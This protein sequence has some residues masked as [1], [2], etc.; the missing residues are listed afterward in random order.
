[1][2]IA[3]AC[4]IWWRALL[5][6]SALGVTMSCS[7]IERLTA[8]PDAQTMEATVL[9]IANVRYFVDGG[10]QTALSAEFLRAYEREVLY[11]RKNGRPGKLPPAIYLAVSGGGDNGAFGAGLLIGWS[12]QGTRPSFKAVTGI[13]AGALIAPF[14]LLGSEYDQSLTDVFTKIDQKDIFLK[15]PILAA[16]N[17]SALS[18]TKPLFDLI[19]KYL[20]NEMIEKI[21]REYDKGRLLLIATT[22]LDASKPVIWNIGAIARSG[23]PDAPELIRKILLASASI[24]GVFPPVMFNVQVGG[25]VHQELHAD[26]GVVAQTFLYPP[27]I[28]LRQLTAEARSAGLAAVELRMR[29]RVAYIIRN[30]KL[31]DDWKQVEPKTLTIAGRAVSTLINNNGV[32][33]MYRIYG[34]TKRDGVDYNLA[35]IDSDFTEPHTELFDRGYMNKLFDYGRAKA[36]GGYPWRKKPPGLVQ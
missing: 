11:A 20:D 9:G 22:N 33:D 27:T 13:S 12:E 10:P 8:V 25:E 23:H 5:A 14:A 30:G 31:S 16:L 2:A 26:G 32:G 35:F 17:E 4:N 7:Q 34:T 3:P 28:S 19:T 15:R 24:P 18:D 36:K 29:K 21:G 1:M 6:V